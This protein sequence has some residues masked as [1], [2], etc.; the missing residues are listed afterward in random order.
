VQYSLGGWGGAD[1]FS[2]KIIYGNEGRLYCGKGKGW[3]NGNRNE[4]I[5]GGVYGRGSM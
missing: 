5:G 3:V 2:I 1:V 4:S